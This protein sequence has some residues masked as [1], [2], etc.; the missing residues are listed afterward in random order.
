MADPR[1]TN[2]RFA[3]AIEFLRRRLALPGDRWSELVREI[4]QAAAERARGM[5]DAL[6]TDILKAV[7]KALEEGTGFADFLDDFQEATRRHGWIASDAG[8]D[9]NAFET[10]RRAQLAFRMLTQQ[11][12]AAGRWTQI[13]RLKRARPYLRY[14]HVDPEL[15]QRWS[16]HEHAAWHGVIL[17]VDHE[18]WLTH[19]PPNGW[20]CRCYVMSV[21]ER[22]LVRYGWTVSEQAPESVNV[23]RFVRGRPVETPAGIDPGFAYNVGIVGLRLPEAA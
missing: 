21:S 5:S 9:E 19:Y 12:Y 16:R 11:A 14:V 3:E 7:L 13:Q 20:F 22:D 10:A 1:G 15:T 18:W 8:A 6:M 23:I 4:D 17:P 2:V